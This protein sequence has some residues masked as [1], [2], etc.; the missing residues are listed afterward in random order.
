MLAASRSIFYRNRSTAVEQIRLLRSIFVAGVGWQQQ[1]LSPKTMQI[2][3]KIS[4]KKEEVEE[5]QRK[6]KIA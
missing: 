2:A 1:L 6:L 5:N 3:K 4:K